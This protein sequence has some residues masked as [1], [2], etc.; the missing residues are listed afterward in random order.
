MHFV[1]QAL[2]IMQHSSARKCTGVHR[3]T[4]GNPQPSKDLKT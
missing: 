4:L 2:Q 1:Q 3:T